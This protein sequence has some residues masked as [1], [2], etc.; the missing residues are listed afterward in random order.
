MRCPNQWKRWVEDLNDRHRKWA[1]LPLLPVSVK[2]STL[3]KLTLQPTVIWAVLK[4]LASH[5]W[6]C[7][8]HAFVSTFHKVTQIDLVVGADSTLLFSPLRV[9]K[10][11]GYLLV[12]PS[13]KL[14][15][16]TMNLRASW[17]RPWSIFKCSALRIHCETAVSLLQDCVWIQ[18]KLR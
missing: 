8:A 4:N 18:A 15:E 2:K 10:F 9:V 17:L 16:P 3:I 14:P 5:L 7:A 1:L 13:P 11:L 6:R 12:S